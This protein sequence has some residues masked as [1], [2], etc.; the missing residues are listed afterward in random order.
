MLLSTL[1]FSIFTLNGK[2]TTEQLYYDFTDLEL[3]NY[4]DLNLENEYNQS[5]NIITTREYYSDDYNA[6]Y[7]FYNETGTPIGWTDNSGVGCSTG[8]ISSL[9]GH[10]YVLQCYDNSDPNTYHIYNNFDTSINNGTIEFFIA[11]SDI[12]K[13]SLVYITDSG[14][15]TNMYFMIRDSK[16]RYYDG[17]NQDIDIDI[18]PVNNAWYHIRLDFETSAGNYLGLSQHTFR[19]TINGLENNVDSTFNA[20]GGNDLDVLNFYSAT[21]DFGYYT[22]YDAIGYNWLNNYSINENIRSIYS[23]NETGYSRPNKFMFDMQDANQ[24]YDDGNGNPSGWTDVENYA[25]EVR[26]ETPEL[27]EYVN[28]SK[29]VRITQLIDPKDNKGVEKNFSI[30]SNRINISMS[31]NYFYTGSAINND[32]FHL[33]AYSN[34]ST[35][36]FSCGYHVDALSIP[37]LTYW[38]GSKHIQLNSNY[39]NYSDLY[40]I[41]SF[42]DYYSNLAIVD[43][44]INNTF[45]NQYTI[46]LIEGGKSG[47][48]KIFAAHF[49]L[50]FHFNIDLY[51]I[52][53]YDN[54]LTV[55]DD[56]CCYSIPLNISSWNFNE[57]NLF[58]I[59]IN[60]VINCSLTASQY[61][62]LES[63]LINSQYYYNDSTIFRNIYTE[64]GYSLVNPSFQLYF[65][66]TLN[67]ST[68]TITSISVSGACVIQEGNVYFLEFDYGNVDIQNNFFYV[69]TI[70]RLRY[71]LTT[72]ENNTE[73]IQAS[74]DIDDISTNNRFVSFR[75]LLY[76]LAT[77]TFRMQYSATSEIIILD[78]LDRSYTQLLTEGLT[79]DKF[80][81]LITD[82]NELY[83]E[84]TTGY[85]RNLVLRYSISDTTAISL[86]L[87]E[88][89]VPLIILLIPSIAIS[90]TYGRNL[91]VPVF[92][93]CSIICVVSL[94]IPTWLF[95][96]IGFNSLL[97]IISKKDDLVEFQ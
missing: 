11:T 92:L 28:N 87:I 67:I 51:D 22:F 71:N 55:S 54:G 60:G 97:F 65:Y 46:P 32:L 91:L 94:L 14:A 84:S 3:F 31:W 9:N 72:N 37:Y 36:V 23:I 68:I 19:T 85:F 13:E 57:Y 58:D 61:I 25:G 47:L 70:G 53:V 88:M 1:L 42:I 6:S 79:L 8:L 62:G 44:Y 18:T 81:I 63:N 74:F 40:S 26:I 50:S 45:N 95:F 12:S 20:K 34:D 66:G 33:Q 7:S 17:S 15:T 77:G 30:N 38:D 73:Y 41:N 27:T 56:F 93:L 24:F 82:D 86:V 64:S 59:S 69:D 29:V 2:S 4:T 16:F 80:V 96:I 21:V 75:A 35:L 89:L 52:G 5:Y 90:N 10:S 43:F 76:G 39:L 83:T 49:S 48:S 78:Q